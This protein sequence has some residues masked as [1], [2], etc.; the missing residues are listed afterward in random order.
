MS[1]LAVASA[2]RNF[3]A[4]ILHDLQGELS[5]VTEKREQLAV[6]MSETS[7]GSNSAAEAEDKALEQIQKTL[8]TQQKLLEGLLKAAEDLLKSGAKGMPKFASNA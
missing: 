4:G 6:L 7:S 3:F 2:H 1:N 8:E 5:E